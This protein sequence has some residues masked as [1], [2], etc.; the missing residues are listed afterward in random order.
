MIRGKK[1]SHTRIKKSDFI[2]V[3]VQRDKI[4]YGSYLKL[5]E[6]TYTSC[7]FPQYVHSQKEV[8]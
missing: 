3:K 8:T 1:Q 6:V 4:R 2:Y 7:K 5:G